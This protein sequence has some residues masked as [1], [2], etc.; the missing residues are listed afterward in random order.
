ML[1]AID[2]AT[3]TASLAL[4]DLEA[5]RL[6]AEWTWEARRRQTQD[7]LGAA[8][9][10]LAQSDRRP[11]DLTALAVT[12]GPGSFTGV[13]I[14]ISTVKGMAIGLIPEPAVIGI[15]TLRV[16]AEPWLRAAAAADTMLCACI[17]AGRGRYNWLGFAGRNARLR[18]DAAAHQAGTA[19]QFAAYLAE[20]PERAVWLT[21][22]VDEALHAAV[23]P[24]ENVTVLPGAGDWRRAGYL[25]GLAAQAIA[26]DDVDSAAELQPLYLRTPG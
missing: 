17:R 1:L 4:Y 14:A 20:Q 21:G 25:A 6:L 26:A 13:R 23:R 9:M 19:P 5:H 24:L 16:T 11:A 3:T 8:K 10:L 15:P 2:T 18:P 12:T 22:E 7:L